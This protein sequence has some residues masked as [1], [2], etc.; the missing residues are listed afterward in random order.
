[1]LNEFIKELCKI[2]IF[3]ILLDIY[4]AGEKPIPDI[5]SL[6]LVKKI[7][8]KNKNVYYLKKKTDLND[9][10]KIYFNEENTIIF[11]GA[12]SITTILAHKLINK[13]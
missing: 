11:M 12:G 5:S 1:M 3:Y 10:L 8:K 7:K 9:I 2:S 4:S 6:N 13:K